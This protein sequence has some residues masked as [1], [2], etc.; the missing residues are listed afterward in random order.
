MNTA[1]INISQCLDNIS[2][3]GMLTNGVFK[4]VNSIE[5]TGILSPPK[6]LIYESEKLILLNS[7]FSAQGGTIFS[8]K[9]KT[10]Q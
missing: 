9:I 6:N 10:C 4:A 2:Q 8:A 5:S 1:T 3:T 7:G